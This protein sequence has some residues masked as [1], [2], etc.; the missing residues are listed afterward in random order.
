MPTHHAEYAD[1]LWEEAI[2]AG[3]T[4]PAEVAG[5]FVRRVEEGD[6]PAIALLLSRRVIGTVDPEVIRRTFAG[7]REEI[8]ARR[9]VRGINVLACREGRWAADMTLAILYGDGTVDT[10]VVALVREY[11]RWRVDLT[12]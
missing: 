9:G 1:V 2:A 10:E 6:M 8:A 3:P 5:E 12:R 11:G 7:S 4:G